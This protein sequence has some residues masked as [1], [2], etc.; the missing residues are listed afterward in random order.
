MKE[1]NTD[2]KLIISIIIVFVLVAAIIGF[3]MTRPASTAKTD[4]AGDQSVPSETTTTTI[5]PNPVKTMEP[6]TAAEKGNEFLKEN[7]TKPGV[8][9]LPSG[10]Q[11]KI[12][13]QGTGPKPTKSQ[14]VKVNYEGTLI[15]GTVFDSSY[16]RGEPIE[17]GVTQVI[18]GW[19]EGLQLMPVGSTYMF[20]I[21]SNLAYGQRGAGGLI[22]PDETLVFKVELLG[23]HN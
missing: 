20:Y 17:F 1:K 22:G 3:A 13:T 21:P 16:K 15:D 9:V 23:A 12:I 8:V 2:T 4:E 18:P 7:A 14:T 6:Q 5:N 19:V 11:Y 10:L